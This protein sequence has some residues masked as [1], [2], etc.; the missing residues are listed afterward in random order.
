MVTAEIYIANTYSIY[1]SIDCEDGGHA[2]TG[3][4]LDGNNVGL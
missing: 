2:K 4:D 1:K 3:T